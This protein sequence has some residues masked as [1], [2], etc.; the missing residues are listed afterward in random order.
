MPP[1]PPPNPYMEVPAYIMPRPHMQPVDTDVSSTPMLRLLAY[2]NPYQPCRVRPHHTD[3]VKETVNSEV[4]TEPQQ[5]GRGVSEESPLISA[6]SGGN[7][8]NPPY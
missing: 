8:R 1:F 7:G 3:P 6:D 2:L 5:R 4:Q